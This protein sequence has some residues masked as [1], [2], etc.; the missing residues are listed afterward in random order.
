VLYVLYVS[1]KKRFFMHEFQCNVYH[2]NGSAASSEEQLA[3]SL[4]QLGNLVMGL[5]VLPVSRQSVLAP[6]LGVSWDKTLRAHTF[7]GV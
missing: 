7:L 1:K 4:G 2:C 5:L 6:L 3:R